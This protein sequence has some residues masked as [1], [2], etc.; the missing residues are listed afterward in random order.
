MNWLILRIDH[1]TGYHSSLVLVNF[2]WSA[3]RHSR[4]AILWGEIN[5]NFI[6]QGLKFRTVSNV[7][8]INKLINDVI[9][10]L[11]SFF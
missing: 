3:V 11:I 8:K 7:W 4:H 2:V 9:V 6:E 10:I 5:T 1:A